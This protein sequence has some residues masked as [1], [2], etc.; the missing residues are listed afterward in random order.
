MTTQTQQQPFIPADPA[1]P[2]GRARE[3][4]AGLEARI[5]ELV[6]RKDAL[7]DRREAAKHA[8]ASLTVDSPRADFIAGAGAQLELGYIE[9]ALAEIARERGDLSRFLKEAREQLGALERSYHA[10]LGSLPAALML[11]GRNAAVVLGRLRDLSGLEPDIA[12]VSG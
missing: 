9:A 8:L 11:G 6:S 7:V 1:S 2:I 4:V 3:R 12:R 5:A 10:E